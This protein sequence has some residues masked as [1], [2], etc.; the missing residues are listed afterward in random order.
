MKKL[1][2]IIWKL[3]Q[4]LENFG[5]GIETLLKKTTDS[6]CELLLGFVEAKAQNF[7]NIFLK[8]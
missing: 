6:D 1:V 2:F 8:H 7:S 3:L 4:S 5:N